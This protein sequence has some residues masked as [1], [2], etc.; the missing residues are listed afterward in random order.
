[1]M[2]SGGQGYP[3]YMAFP[4]HKVV[5]IAATPEK[6]VTT[7]SPSD[8]RVVHQVSLMAILIGTRPDLSFLS[9]EYQDGQ[10]L[11]VSFCRCHNRRKSQD[12]K[13][14]PRTR[15]SP[16]SRGKLAIV[17]TCLTNSLKFV[18]AQKR[19]TIVCIQ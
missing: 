6:K 9:P 11:T 16:L 8:L 7:V 1:M 12:S 15:G 10:A 3:D 17:N 13:G 2:T 18:I 14:C 4:E 5:D 19:K